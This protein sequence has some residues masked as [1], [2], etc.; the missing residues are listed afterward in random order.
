M[1]TSRDGIQRITVKVKTFTFPK[2]GDKMA[3]FSGGCKSTI[4]DICRDDRMPSF[5]DGTYPD[6]IFNIHS[7]STRRSMGIL[8]EGLAT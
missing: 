2:I 8:F 7:L 3:V 1:T 5:E 4:N 6:M